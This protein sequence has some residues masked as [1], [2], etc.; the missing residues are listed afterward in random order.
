MSYYLHE[1]LYYPVLSSEAGRPHF[2]TWTGVVLSPSSCK[3][4]TPR[5]GLDENIHRLTKQSELSLCLQLWLMHF[6][7][8]QLLKVHN[9]DDLKI[10]RLK[11]KIIRWF[12]FLSPAN[13]SRK[14]LS[15]PPTPPQLDG[16]EIYIKK[17]KTA[18]DHFTAVPVNK[19]QTTTN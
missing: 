17:C 2:I 7:L 15:F 14:N 16:Q 19:I 12:L 13:V 3:L 8:H 5:A 9:E 4:R 18:T 10:V 1:T 11:K 6:S